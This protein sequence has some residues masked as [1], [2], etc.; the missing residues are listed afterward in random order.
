MKRRIWIDVGAHLGERTLKFAQEDISLTVYAFEPNMALVHK[1]ASTVANFIVLPLAVT[2][3]NAYTDFN[4]TVKDA[5]SSVLPIVAYSRRT[6]AELDWHMGGGLDIVRSI[7]VPSI[8]LDTF[9][10]WAETEKVEFLKID[11]QGA[12]LSVVKSAGARLR[13]IEKVRLEVAIAPSPYEGAEQQEEVFDF[14]N[15]A[16]FVLYRRRNQSFGQEQNLTFVRRAI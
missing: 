9:M 12:D 8:R 16:G 2:E 3:R 13:D 1:L 7:Q 6:S 4:L 5:C 15:E 14:M 11:A 10:T